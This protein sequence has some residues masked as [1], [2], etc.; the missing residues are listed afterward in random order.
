[1]IF[2]ENLPAWWVTS[3]I[4]LVGAVSLVHRF[5]KDLG[6]RIFPLLGDFSY[7]PNIDKNVLKALGECGLVDIQEF[8]RETIRPDS[9]PIWHPLKRFRH[10]VHG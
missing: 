6:D 3:E 8:R 5:V 1:M 2:E 7:Y 4:P 9:F 10:L